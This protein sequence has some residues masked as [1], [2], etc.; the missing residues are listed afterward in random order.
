MG[1]ITLSFFLSNIFLN[2]DL[3]Y[4]CEQRQ[5]TTTVNW[6]T[7]LRQGQTMSTKLYTLIYSHFLQNFFHVGLFFCITLWYISENVGILECSQKCVSAWIGNWLGSHHKT[8][9][10]EGGKSALNMS[11]HIWIWTVVCLYISWNWLVKNSG[12]RLPLWPQSA[13]NIWTKHFWKQVIKQ[14]AD[15]MHKSRQL[16]ITYTVPGGRNDQY[17]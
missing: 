5:Q 2:Y 1:S 7:D 15:L 16:K 14:I 12:C 13:G 3:L 11:K 17:C 4:Y 8:S 6:N 10:A 9:P